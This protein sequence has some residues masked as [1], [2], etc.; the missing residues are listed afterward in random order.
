MLI[1]IK[2]IILEFGGLKSSLADSFTRYAQKKKSGTMGL[3]T[4]SKKPKPIEK[5]NSNHQASKDSD[6]SDFWD[7]I[8]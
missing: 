5:D 4:I 8:K 2:E 6:S 3:P 1:P 7:A